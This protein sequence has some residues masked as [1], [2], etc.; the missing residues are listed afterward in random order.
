MVAVNNSG[1]FSI[2]ART[3]TLHSNISTYD[4]AHTWLCTEWRGDDRVTAAEVFI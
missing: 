3:L 4:L 2:T 1:T